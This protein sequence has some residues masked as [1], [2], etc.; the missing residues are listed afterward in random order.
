MGYQAYDAGSESQN[1]GGQWGCSLDNHSAAR[2]ISSVVCSLT[3]HGADSVRMVS[4]SLHGLGI[5]GHCHARAQRITESTTFVFRQRTQVRRY[6]GGVFL[7][8][9]HCAADAANV[10]VSEQAVLSMEEAVSV[11][12]SPAGVQSVSLG[13]LASSGDPQEDFPPLSTHGQST[14]A[15]LSRSAL[16]AQRLRRNAGRFL[17]IFAGGVYR[18]RR[19]SHCALASQADLGEALYTGA[20]T[21][22]RSSL[23]QSTLRGSAWR[24]RHG[25]QW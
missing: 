23:P 17:C 2:A 7:D 19:R 6:S 12:L 10:L 9:L 8:P 4:G 24:H 1:G 3:A 25:R 18:E 13:S 20:T 5:G 22:R 21:S 11:R 16:D 14:P 15:V